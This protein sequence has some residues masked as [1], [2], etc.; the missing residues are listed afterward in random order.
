MPLDL[1]WHLTKNGKQT[2]K[3]TKMPIKTK[4]AKL[5]KQ[6]EPNYGSP[7][8]SLNETRNWF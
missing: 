1:Y 3:Q 5:T 6:N 7:T 2:N 8:I 4:E